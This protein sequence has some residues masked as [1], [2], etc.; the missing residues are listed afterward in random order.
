M[1]KKEFYILNNI[2]FKLQ[3]SFS[4]RFRIRNNNFYHYHVPHH[5]KIPTTI[6][7]TKTANARIKRNQKG[8]GKEKARSK[9]VRKRKLKLQ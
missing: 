2:T 1:N 7:Q 4:K 8:I 9:G 6:L 5:P 3:Y